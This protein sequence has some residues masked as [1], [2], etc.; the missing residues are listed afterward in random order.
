MISLGSVTLDIRCLIPRFDGVMICEANGIEHRLIKPNH[1]W[2]N[3]HPLG[4]FG[5]AKSPAG[6]RSSG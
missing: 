1:P 4:R 6:Q 2:T 5:Y 3:G